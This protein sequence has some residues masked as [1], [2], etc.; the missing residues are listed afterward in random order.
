MKVIYT[1]PYNSIF[2]DKMQIARE[3]ICKG[4]FRSSSRI[5][6]PSGCIGYIDGRLLRS[7][8]ANGFKNCNSKEKEFIQER[9]AKYE[10]RFN[11]KLRNVAI[12]A[13]NNFDLIDNGLKVAGAVGIAAGIVTQ[14]PLLVNGSSK[15]L[16]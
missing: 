8:S 6:L 12:F 4:I 13:K 10:E 2:G 5:E 15:L 7:P 9:V 3:K 16:I 14:N 1:A 11:P